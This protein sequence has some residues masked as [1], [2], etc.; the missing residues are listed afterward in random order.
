MISFRANF[1]SFVRSLA[2]PS[3]PL[4]LLHPI[5]ASLPCPQQF[6]IA[7]AQHNSEGNRTR[8]PNVPIR[9]VEAAFPP[10]ILPLVCVVVWLRQDFRASSSFSRPLLSVV[11]NQQFCG[12]HSAGREEPISFPS[13]ALSPSP[14][15]DRKKSVAGGGI[16]VV[17]QLSSLSCDLPRRSS[18]RP[19]SALFWSART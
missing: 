4:S 15:T 12:R 17:V 19:R 13:T 8:V 3:L 9:G 1:S 11:F 16:A 10:S 6:A 14:P 2:L 5:P 18:S 7:R